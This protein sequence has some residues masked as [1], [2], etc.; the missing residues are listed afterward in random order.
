MA[1]NRLFMLGV[2]IQSLLSFGDAVS[3]PTSSAD[4]WIFCPERLEVRLSCPDPK[5]LGSKKQ[6]HFLECTLAR[7][8]VESPYYLFYQPSTVKNRKEANS[9]IGILMRL[10]A[11]NTCRVFSPMEPK[12]YGRTRVSDLA[13]IRNFYCKW[14]EEVSRNIPI[15]QAP[16]NHAPCIPLGSNLERENLRWVKPRNSEPGSTKNECI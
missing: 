6:I 3:R 7:F 15:A 16:A 2:N 10:T 12:I 1:R 5:G 11:P 13:C 9:L 4:I 14:G 8:R